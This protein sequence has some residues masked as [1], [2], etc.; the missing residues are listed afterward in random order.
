MDRYLQLYI[1]SLD[2]IDKHHSE[3]SYVSRLNSFVEN[4]EEI[5]L[6]YKDGSKIHI[7]RP[8]YVLVSDHVK[9]LTKDLIKKK[10]EYRQLVYSY[11]FDNVKP[12][13]KKISKY[14][15]DLLKIEKDLKLMQKKNQNG[16]IYYHMIKDPKI[17]PDNK[18]VNEIVEKVIDNKADKKKPV[19][20]N[21]EK[22]REKL[23]EEIE[24][25]AKKLFKKS[26]YNSKSP[27]T[28]KDMKVFLFKSL[29]ECNTRPNKSNNSMSREN[30]IKEMLNNP[31]LLKRLPPGY[32]TKSKDEICKLLF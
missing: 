27:L 25:K 13:I 21:S 12:D 11:L 23:F 19:T 28:D 17:L 18:V 24:N 4:G 30:I 32:Q 22:E 1:T 6:S 29:Q 31:K 8:K 9:R 2:D 7:E 14:L 16:D 10:Q 26:I 15:E 3:S 5:R 20:E